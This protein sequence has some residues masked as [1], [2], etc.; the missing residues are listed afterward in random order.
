MLR[1][2]EFYGFSQYFHPQY[3]PTFDLKKIVW[4]TRTPDYIE[5]QRCID[6]N[7]LQKHAD[8]AAFR[9]NFSILDN[10]SK[11][12]NQRLFARGY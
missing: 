4:V 8:F 7:I 10:L 6:I 12:Q 2:A 5:I 3:E 9:E 1:K 11:E